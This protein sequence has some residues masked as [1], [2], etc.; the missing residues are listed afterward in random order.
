MKLARVVEAEISAHADFEA[1]IQGLDEEICGV[2]GNQNLS[3]TVLRNDIDTDGGEQLVKVAKNVAVTKVV[4]GVD[5]G[6]PMENQQYHAMVGPVDV[7]FNPGW[8]DKT[9]DKKSI[10]GDVKGVKS[11]AQYVKSKIAN[12][13]D[14]A[15]SQRQGSWVRMNRPNIVSNNRDAIIKERPKRK[16]QVVAQ[17]GSE[18]EFEKKVKIDEEAR[19]LSSLMASE[20][21][22]AEVVEQPYRIQ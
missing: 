22:A 21:R 6:E 10:K 18:G 7:I 3:E 9:A 13:L 1:V 4:H 19:K 16:A 2:K 17:C 11:G 15:G 5:R 8:A 20:F 14:V 12:N